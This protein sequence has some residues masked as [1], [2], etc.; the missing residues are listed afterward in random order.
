MAEN[1]ME[2]EE[3]EFTLS[4]VLHI[5]TVKAAYDGAYT[6]YLERQYFGEEAGKQALKNVNLYAEQLRDLLGE[7]ADE[8]LES[9][10]AWDIDEDG[11]PMYLPKVISK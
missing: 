4:E 3:K 2:K 9:V 8:L 1:I 6:I 10:G 11:Q 5:A 7:N